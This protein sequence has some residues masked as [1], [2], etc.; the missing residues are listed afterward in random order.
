M[1]TLIAED[2]LLLLLDDDKGTATSSY[3]DVALGGALLVELALAEAVHVRE[4]TSVWS[5]AKVAA[6][7]GATV[8]D[9]VL[10]GALDRVAERERSATDLVQRLGRG[11]KDALATRLVERGLLV[12]QDD[13]ILGL[14]PRTRWLAAD[15][16]HEQEVRRALTAVLVQGLEPGP[17]TGALVALLSAVD[18]A[19]ASVDHHGVP[20][21][22]VRRRAKQVAEG[23]WA[24]A[25]VRDAIAASVAATTAAITAA[26]VVTTTSG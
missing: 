24:A 20:T 23:A 16:T 2:L 11:V 3:L 17:R 15:S 25:A 13:R 5:G 7:P 10:A 8:A 18:K 9:P 14:F 6:T 26:T 12:R 4:R 1:T 22:E 21:R 19:P